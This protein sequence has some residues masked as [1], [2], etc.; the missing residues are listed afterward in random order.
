LLGNA[1]SVVVVELL[2]RGLKEKKFFRTRR[3]EGYEYEFP[4]KRTAASS[5]VAAAAAAAAGSSNTAVKYVQA[6]SVETEPW[7]SSEE[8]EDGKPHAVPTLPARPTRTR[9]RLEK[10]PPVSNSGTRDLDHDFSELFGASDQNDDD[11][12]D[13]DSSLDEICTRKKVTTNS[14]D[15]SRVPRKKTPAAAA[16]ND[17]NLSTNHFDLSRVPRKKTPAAAAAAAAANDLNLNTNRFD[18]SRVPRKKTPAAAANG[19]TE[20]DGN[21]KGNEQ[22]SLRSTSPSFSASSTYSTSS[23]STTR[24][25]FASISSRKR[26]FAVQVDDL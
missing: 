18:L 25:L 2:L 13:D 15:L 1:F 19:R 11:D 10:V 26:K 21:S 20:T 12:D 3:Y 24:D 23:N 5:S 7:S 6:L 17:L 22:A 14:F 8:E 4:W 16:A 9:T